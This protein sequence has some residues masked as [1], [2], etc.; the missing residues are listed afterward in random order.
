MERENGW[1]KGESSE[2]SRI[3][4]SVDL[5]PQCQG[6]V[7]LNARRSCRCGKKRVWWKLHSKRGEGGEGGE[8]GGGRGGSWLRLKKPS[9]HCHVTCGL[10][11]YCMLNFEL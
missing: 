2:G 6:T 10:S 5:T 9:H 1:K 3:S 7:S 11:H 8:D 4:V